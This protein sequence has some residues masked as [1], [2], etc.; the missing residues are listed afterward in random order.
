MASQATPPLHIITLV[1][2]PRSLARPNSIRLAIGLGARCGA[3]SWATKFWK[4]S[5]LLPAPV[6]YPK[7]LRRTKSIGN[8]QNMSERLD[9]STKK[10]S[11]KQ[12][13]MTRNYIVIKDSLFF[14]EI[15]SFQMNVLRNR[16]RN[17]Q[18]SLI[19]GSECG[20][21]ARRTNLQSRP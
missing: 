11:K 7:E 8:I 18:C 4:S 3:E 13:A 20:L 9:E 19:L 5:K 16:C 1:V 10:N 12:Q 6:V 2:L 15:N 14:L 17:V 21:V